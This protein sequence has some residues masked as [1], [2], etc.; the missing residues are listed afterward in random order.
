[1]QVTTYL[2]KFLSILYP[3]ICL[4]CGDQ[5]EADFELC[6]RCKHTL[7]WIRYA[8]L[9][10]G[11]PLTTHNASSCGA[12]SNRTLYFEKTITPF[13]YDDFIKEAI[14]QFKFNSK[15]HYG[16][17][18]ANLFTEYIQQRKIQLPDVLVPVP[19][20]KKRI[21]ERGFNQALEIAR[22][23]N[24]SMGVDIRYRDIKR[25]RDTKTQMELPAK[26]RQSNV[27]NAFEIINSKYS[28]KNMR[29]AVLDDVMTTGNTV[30][31]VAKCLKTAGAKQIDAWCI[32]RVIIRY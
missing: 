28:F 16:K 15:L 32:A 12:C 25:I 8:C 4:H 3:S 7:P 2:H 11:L 18:L 5:G 29:V 19:L 13:L 21:R 31:E 10:C 26:Q 20:Y 6:A 22:I 24:K 1:M 17:L 23:V 30:N 14:H 27:K 9:Q